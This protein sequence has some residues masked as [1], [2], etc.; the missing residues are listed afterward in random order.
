MVQVSVLSPLDAS[1]VFLVFIQLY[2]SGLCM[3][4]NQI[5]HAFVFQN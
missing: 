1:G 3:L 5:V 2:N 4:G